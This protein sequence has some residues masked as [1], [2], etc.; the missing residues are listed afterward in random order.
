[1]NNQGQSLIGIIII[2]VTVVLISGGLYSYFQ[3]QTP[4]ILEL[5]KKG[6][7]KLDETILLPEEE[8]I[9]EDIIAQTEKITTTSTFEKPIVQ[10]C[11]DGTLYGQCSINKPKYCEKGNLIDKCSSCGC[12]AEAMC[13]DDGICIK[14]GR[15]KI[16]NVGFIIFKYPD[17]ILPDVLYCQW[18]N[19]ERT[20]AFQECYDTNYGGKGEILN[21]YSVLDIITDSVDKE[22]IFKHNTIR[23]LYYLPDYF[24]REALK[25]S[26][27]L[28]I[29]FYP[30]GIF[31]LT[32]SLPQIY[33]RP[34]GFL[35]TDYHFFVEQAEKKIN[36]SSFDKLIIIFLNDQDFQERE[37]NFAFRSAALSGDGAAILNFRIKGDLFYNNYIQNL[38]HEFQHVLGASDLY[39]EP[40]PRG[41][42]WSCC[43]DPEGMPEP[44]KIPKYPQT[45]ACSMCSTIQLKVDGEGQAPEWENIVICEK[46]AEEIGWLK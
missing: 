31:D 15:S 39:L 41:P 5:S 32:E 10:K 23:S 19:S 7:I 28:K 25:Y 26:L 46:T 44:D 12:P 27:D 9:E 33:K 38:S 13:K 17:T 21:R 6:T 18:P 24:A 8:E 16:I 37:E 35:L 43:K 29:N 1:M 3:K 45:K 30:Q 40:C 14:I 2:L 42:Y 11:V 22:R 34:T 20:L 4:E 36:L